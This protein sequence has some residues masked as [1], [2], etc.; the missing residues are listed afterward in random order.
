MVTIGLQPRRPSGIDG[1]TVERLAADNLRR[2]QI[3]FRIN[4]QRRFRG[5]EILRRRPPADADIVLQK[6]VDG[7]Q[8][9]ARHAAVQIHVAVFEADGRRVRLRLCEINIREGGLACVTDDERRLAFRTR[10]RFKDLVF[11]SRHPF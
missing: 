1:E 3:V 7:V 6:R 8:R 11:Y 2:I 5:E 4:D 9:A 10:R